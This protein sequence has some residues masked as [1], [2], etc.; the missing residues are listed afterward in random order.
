MHNYAYK[1]KTGSRPA[2]CLAGVAG[3]EPATPGFGDLCS[4]QLSYTPLSEMYDANNTLIN[5]FYQEKAFREEPFLGITVCMSQHTITNPTV[6]ITI[7]YPGAGKSFFSRQFAE[8]TGS[9]HLS[10]DRIRA[11]LYETPEYTRQEDEVVYRIMDY[12]IESLIKTGQSIIIDGS[13]NRLVR[14]KRIRD[15]IKK[16]GHRELIVWVQTDLNTAF[17]RASNRDR[18]QADDKYTASISQETF[19]R[20]AA[21]F[22]KPQYEDYAVISGKHVFKNQLNAVLRKLQLPTGQTSTN[23]SRTGTMEP[24]HNKSLLGGRVDMNRRAYKPRI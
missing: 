22:K 3:L 15:L 13:N 24:V 14:R 12:M 5:P 10:E 16:S 1:Q 9:I 4:S 17:D 11:E 8:T 23:Q 19:E 7:G 6:F 18:R 21:I 2:F 20:L